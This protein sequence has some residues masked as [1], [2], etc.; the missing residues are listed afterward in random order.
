[1]VAA[2]KRVLVVD[3]E[4][5]VRESYKLALTEAGYDVRTV[6]S[7]R[8]ALQACRMEH[9]DVMLADIRMPDMDGLEVSRVVAREFPDVRVII[10]TGYP[11]PES[12]ARARKLGVSDYLQKPVAPDRLSAA[13]AAALA[14]PLKRAPEE[15]ASEMPVVNPPAAAVQCAPPNAA[16]P[17]VVAPEVPAPVQVSPPPAV[18]DISAYTAFLVLLGSPLIGLAY[19]LLFPFVATA[20]A[21]TV[22]GKEIAK[23]IGKVHD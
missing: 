4:E 23:L 21:V 8:E 16:A 14:C 1:M 6:P 9:F 19:F 20:I 2:S 11:S 17:H 3:D 12:A 18:D 15:A 13:T 10:I 22:L 7:G 5:I